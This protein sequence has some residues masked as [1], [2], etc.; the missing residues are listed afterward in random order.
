MYNIHVHAHVCT[1]NVRDACSRVRVEGQ[2][3]IPCFWWRSNVVNNVEWFQVNEST[4]AVT[5]RVVYARMYVCSYMCSMYVCVIEVCAC[6]CACM[7]VCVCVCV[8]VH[9]H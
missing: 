2:G 9:E 8:C 5:C 7:C 4:V 3:Y 1:C 6:A